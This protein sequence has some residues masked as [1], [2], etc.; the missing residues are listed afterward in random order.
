M[1]DANNSLLS[2]HQVFVSGAVTRC[3]LLSSVSENDDGFEVTM[4]ATADS[5]LTEEGVAQIQVEV[6]PPW[7]HFVESS[8]VTLCSESLVLTGFSAFVQI[9]QEDD[10]SLLSN[11]KAEVSPVSQAWFTTK[12]DKDTLANK[13]SFPPLITEDVSDLNLC[14]FSFG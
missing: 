11:Q 2:G 6:K 8:L 7:L 10:E 3:L 4:T 12:E 5:D 9:L 1:F 13:G 14:G